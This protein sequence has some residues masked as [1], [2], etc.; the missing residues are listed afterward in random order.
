MILCTFI[1]TISIANNVVKAFYL[2]LNAFVVTGIMYI[3]IND[4]NKKCNK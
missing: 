4:E 3:G 1:F 2:K